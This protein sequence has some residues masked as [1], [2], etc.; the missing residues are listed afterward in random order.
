M[1][2]TTPTELELLEF[3]DRVPLNQKELTLAWE[4]RDYER[5]RLLVKEQFQAAQ[6]VW[7]IAHEVCATPVSFP[8]PAEPG[9]PPENYPWIQADCDKSERIRGSEAAKF[10]GLT[11]AALAKAWKELVPSAWKFDENERLSASFLRLLETRKIEADR[12]RKADREKDR[13]IR[14]KPTQEKSEKL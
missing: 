8:E 7:Q 2:K 13:R 5:I 4:C 1:R 9:L 12:K 6:V 11:R 10:L 14:K 3:A